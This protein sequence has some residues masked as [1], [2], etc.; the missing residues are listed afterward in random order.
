MIFLQC[1]FIHV[2]AQSGTG[3]K[4]QETV[5]RRL[6]AARTRSRRAFRGPSRSC[7]TRHVLDEEIG[8]AGRQVQGRG[9]SHRSAVVVRRDRHVISLRQYGDPARAANAPHARCPAARRPPVPR[10]AAP[11]K[12]PRRVMPRPKPNGVTVS[13]ETLRTTSRL[14][15]E[16]GSSNHSGWLLSMAAATRRRVARRQRSVRASARSRDPRAVV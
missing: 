16:H 1:R 4:L 13:P 15:T 12:R 10:A 8:H 6:Q 3:R 7:G 9:G 14:D 5:A 2:N 11:E